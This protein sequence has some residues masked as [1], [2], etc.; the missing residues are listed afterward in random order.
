VDDG[1][2]PFGGKLE[3][4]SGADMWSVNSTDDWAVDN[5]TG[6]KYADQLIKYIQEDPHRL[7]MLGHVLREIVRKN[8]FGALEVGFSHRIAVELLGTTRAT[9]P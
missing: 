4:V 8:R 7:P 1:V 5:R 3:F 2:A 9:A 6:A